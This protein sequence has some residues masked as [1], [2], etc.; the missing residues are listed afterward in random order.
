[1]HIKFIIKWNERMSY[2]EEKRTT[3]G[4][5]PSTRRRIRITK[6]EKREHTHTHFSW[7]ME[8]HIYLHIYSNKDERPETKLS[9]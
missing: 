5:Q 7:Q 9:P 4:T 3:H 2:T 6:G 1:M 8:L